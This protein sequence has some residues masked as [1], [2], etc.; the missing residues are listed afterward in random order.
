MPHEAKALLRIMTILE[1]FDIEA[2]RRLVQF[3]VSKVGLPSIED[4]R[5]NDRERQQR[6]RDSSRDMSQTI[7]TNDADADIHPVVSS[8]SSKKKEQ[9]LSQEALDR[10]KDTLESR[11]YEFLKA[12]PDP[13]RTQWLMNPDWWISLRDGYPKIN[14]LEQASRYMSWEGARRKRDHRA[15][16]R[17][18]LSTAERWRERNEMAKA[19]RR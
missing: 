10:A 18:W 11:D 13:F 19:A 1:E 9:F 3:Q 5:A 7:V 8:S 14:A 2:Q 15:A 17:N 6:S 12:C 16:L 4:R